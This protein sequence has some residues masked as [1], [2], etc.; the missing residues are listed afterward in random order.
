MV[1]HHK[2]HKLG[3]EWFDFGRAMGRVVGGAER[4]GLLGKQGDVM[5]VWDPMRAIFPDPGKSW[6]ESRIPLWYAKFQRAGERE[7]LK[8]VFASSALKKRKHGEHG[9]TMKTSWRKM[10]SKSINKG[11]NR[12][13]RSQKVKDWDFR[14]RRRY[15]ERYMDS[16]SH[17]DKAKSGTN[18]WRYGECSLDF[19]C[20]RCR[21]G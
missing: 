21:G 12:H 3:E 1:T 15:I 13:Q 17:C 10:C 16:R 19:S 11:S 4:H 8:L 9:E 20:C 18:C 6:F 2:F 5:T 7:V 14:W